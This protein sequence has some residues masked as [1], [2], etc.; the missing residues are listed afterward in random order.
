MSGLQRLF[1]R[2]TP[3]ITL[4]CFICFGIYHTFE[5]NQTGSITY[6]SKEVITLNDNA[7]P[8][9]T[10]DDLTIEQYKFDT[11]S[12]VENINQDILKRSTNNV[13]DL[14]IYE[15]NLATFN[16]IWED[17]YNFGDGI[18]TI[19]N[20]GLLL[21][22]TLIL[23]I[24]ILLVPL[25]I[26]AGVLLTAFSIVGINVNS[27]T[28]IINFLN[29]ILD[30]LVIPLID[31]TQNKEGNHEYD[32]TVWYFVESA[33]N[34]KETRAMNIQFTTTIDGQTKTY[35]WITVGR[36][37]I[38]YSTQETFGERYTLMN[39]YEWQ[40]E[41]ARYITVIN[42]GTGENNTHTTTEL[43]LSHFATQIGQPIELHDTIW[44][45]NN[46]ITNISYDNNTKYEVIFGSNGVNYTAI[47]LII[48]TN[49][50]IKYY[51]KDANNQEQNMFVYTN[52][53]WTNQQ[54]RTI[55]IE[56]YTTDSAL[57]AML[58]TYAIRIS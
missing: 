28:P 26:I 40:N 25:R 50:S 56:Q 27:E 16:L 8:E 45:F 13:A 42:I 36:G 39:N 58:S 5:T 55:Q 30:N 12:Y 57:L 7:T 11:K 3:I 38:V 48:G 4:I 14:T 21:I 23:P 35:N 49:P 52:G 17:G 54:Y 43:W 10:T 37:K 15:R 34:H 46:S 20:V 1:L 22:N 53:T 2:I 19:I 33:S 41:I 29:T 51:W 47:E 44:Q 6:L 32:N 9:D 18:Q 31:P 24:N